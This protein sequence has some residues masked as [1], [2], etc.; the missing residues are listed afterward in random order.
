MV[1]ETGSVLELDLVDQSAPGSWG[2]SGDIP[3]A[4]VFRVSGDAGSL[5]QGN[6]LCGDRPVT[7]IAAWNEDLSGFRYLGVALFTGTEIPR[8]VSGEDICGTYFYST[9]VVEQ[10]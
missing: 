3:L 10:G 5:R 6:T 1:F 7:Y 9:D 4:Q 2:A 8:A